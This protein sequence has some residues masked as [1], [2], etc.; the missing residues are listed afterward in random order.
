[1]RDATDGTGFAGRFANGT[2]LLELGRNRLVL[3]RERN[4]TPKISF[5]ARAAVE[6]TGAA[7]FEGVD[8]PMY[9]YFMTR[10]RLVFA[11]RDL[12]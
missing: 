2:L 1:M 3:S 11:T 9:R 8:G 5:V 7:S 6:H 4:R 10:N 12:Y